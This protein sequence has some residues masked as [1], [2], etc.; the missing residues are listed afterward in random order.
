ML[1]MACAAVA[2]SLMGLVL[3]RGNARHE[4]REYYS[5]AMVAVGFLVVFGSCLTTFS[6][7]RFY[8][9]VY[10]SFQM[11]MIFGCLAAIAGLTER[12]ETL[13]KSS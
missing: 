13:R 1:W 9:P 6:A 4:Q 3:A 11:A 12:L 10:S 5:L 8:L 7:A 2:F